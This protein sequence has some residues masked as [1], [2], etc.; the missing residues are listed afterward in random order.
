[1]PCMGRFSTFPKMPPP[2]PSTDGAYIAVNIDI[3]ILHHDKVIINLKNPFIAH[4]FTHYPRITFIVTA[5]WFLLSAITVFECV[6]PAIA[7]D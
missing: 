5:M 1:M 2:P 6:F 3:L 7:F 4:F